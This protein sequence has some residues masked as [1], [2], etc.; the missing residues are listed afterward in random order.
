M[1]ADAVWPAHHAARVARVLDQAVE[2]VGVPAS[3]E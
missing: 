2:R 1:V 3:R